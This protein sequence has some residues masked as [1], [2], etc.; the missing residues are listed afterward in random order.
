M[1]D[2]IVT[3]RATRDDFRAVLELLRRALG[4]V[5]D[6]ARFLEWK[7]LQSPFGESPMWVA[8][9][10]PRI[11]GF[12]AFLRWEL[13]G[14]DGR[15]R[16]AARAVDTA[17]DPDFEGRGI[18][19]RLTL[20]AVAALPGEGVDLVFNTPNARSL[21]GYLKMGWAEVGR[22]S[23]A[24][25]PARWRFATV[26]ATARRPAERGNVATSVG[27]PAGEGLADLR[28]VDRLLESAAAPLGL[29]THRSSGYLQWRYGHPDLG[30]RVLV[31]GAPADPEGLLVFRLRRR[32][33]AVEGVID[34]LVVPRG[35]PE[36]ARSLVDR[37]AR[38]R[39]ADYLIR[40]QDSRVTRDRF[41]RLPQV[42]PI[43]VGRSLTDIPVPD[44]RGW[45]PSMGDVE[46]L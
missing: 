46:L 34:D 31:H 17:T 44:R 2:D 1:V 13:V 26:V 12:R 29:A 3:R 23:A 14:P 25:R 35:S 33:A 6:D 43:L 18:F 21:P 22:L 40:L 8:L 4:W 7:H 30:Y 20:E 27:I 32:G 19:T 39:E 9:A 36:V 41:V 37:L 10:G 16:H 28:L 5:D 15:V 38:A 11:V 45:A 42:G 24:V